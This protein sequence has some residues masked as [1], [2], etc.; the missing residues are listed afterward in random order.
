MKSKNIYIFCA[1]FFTLENNECIRLSESLQIFWEV[2]DSKLFILEYFF[3]KF[4]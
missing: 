3:W 1:E 2:S 4:T